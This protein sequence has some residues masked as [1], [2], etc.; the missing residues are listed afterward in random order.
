MYRIYDSTGHATAD[1]ITHDWE[2]VDMS[3]PYKCIDTVRP[4]KDVE[5]RD[6][7]AR[8]LLRKVIS[9]G[10]RVVGPVPL[11]DIRDRVRDQ[12]M[13]EIWEEEQRFENP[14]VHHMD[15][16]VPYYNDKMDL[17]RRSQGS[18]L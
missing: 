6:C 3:A 16:S 18:P 9:N 4:W 5:L 17:L 7:T 12:L 10:E 11:S 1:L 15:M 2:E 8:P 14:H 13:N